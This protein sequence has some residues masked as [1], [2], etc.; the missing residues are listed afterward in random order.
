MYNKYSSVIKVEEVVEEKQ[1]IAHRG[2]TRSTGLLWG[3]Y[4]LCVAA[5]LGFKLRILV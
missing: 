1:L 5:T 4:C 2:Q 3:F